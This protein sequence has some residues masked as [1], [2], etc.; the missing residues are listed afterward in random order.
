MVNDNS[1]EAL[2]A[3]LYNDVLHSGDTQLVHHCIDSLTTILLPNCSTKETRERCTQIIDEYL[4]QH[5]VDK[6]SLESVR[7]TLYQEIAVSDQQKLLQLFIKT[8]AYVGEA[9]LV[10][11]SQVINEYHDA[12]WDP[13]QA[14]PYWIETVVVRTRDVELVKKTIE[15]IHACRNHL[16]RDEFYENCDVVLDDSTELA[17]IVHKCTDKYD[18]SSPAAKDVF[19]K[20]LDDFCAYLSQ[21]KQ[22]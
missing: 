20:A 21:K 13:K 9:P 4:A 14:V 6:V 2:G 17:G 22:Q 3:D 10:E 18:R 15:A 7:K 1:L 12:P 19:M 8:L 11:I 5:I 16:A